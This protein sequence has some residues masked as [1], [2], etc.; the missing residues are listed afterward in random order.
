MIPGPKVYSDPVGPV[1]MFA[2]A[3]T[4]AS[5]GKGRKK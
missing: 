4:I 5:T 3:P 1:T 2:D